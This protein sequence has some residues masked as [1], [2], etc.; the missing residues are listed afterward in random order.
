MKGKKIIN[1]MQVLSLGLQQSYDQELPL[2]RQ[3]NILLLKH[4]PA[5][6]KKHTHTHTHTHTQIPSTE[7]KKRKKAINT[8]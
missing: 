4:S 5:R 2:H 3:K 7:K 8:H 1:K 6:F